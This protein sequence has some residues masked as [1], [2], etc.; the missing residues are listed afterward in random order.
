[1]DMDQ[2]TCR[3]IIGGTEYTVVRPGITLCLLHAEPAVT[4]A[5]AIADIVEEYINF[6]PDGALQTYLSANGTW[7]KATKRTFTSALGKLRTTGRGEYAE[8]HFGQEPLRNVGEYGAHF[9]GSPLADDFF[10]LETC[11]LYLEF[12]AN[13]SEFT[14][15]DK[16]I[17][18]VHRVAASRDFDSGFCGYA[19]KHLHMSLRHE[20][21]KAIGKMAMRY[22][23]FDISNDFI[24]MDARGHVCNISWLTLFGGEITATLG[25]AGEIRRN[26][27]DAVNI[28]KLGSGVIVRATESPIRGDVNRGATD[29]VT[30]RRLSEITRSLR[31]EVPNLGPDDPDFA[32]RWLSRFDT[33]R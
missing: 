3:I 25:G 2:L 33:Q 10:P 16:F 22:I 24:R 13:L 15:I 17:E 1:M 32:Q 21:F 31:L 11:I 30:L 27:P 4:L 19:F 29:A 18:F 6:I 14:N 20:A 9:K 28:S 8:F 23:G 12:P 7:K 5:P 26:F